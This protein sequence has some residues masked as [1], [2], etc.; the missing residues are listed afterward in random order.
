MQEYWRLDHHV[1]VIPFL[2]E[3]LQTTLDKF[4]GRPINLSR[5]LKFKECM[6]HCG[7]LDLGFSGP[8]FTWTNLRN[9]RALIRE[10]LDRA[11]S[12]H[13]W[14]LLFPATKILHLPRTHSDHCPLLLNIHPLS[15]NNVNRPFRFETI[16]FSDPSLFSVVPDSWAQHPTSFLRSVTTFTSKVSIWNKTSF[17]NIFL[18]KRRLERRLLGVQKALDNQSYSFLLELEKALTSELNLTLKL[19]EEFWALKSRVNTIL[20]GDRNSKFFHIT[21]INRRRNN[22]I[23]ALKDTSGTWIST[24]WLK[25][26]CLSTEPHPSSIPWAIVFPLACWTIWKNRNSASFEP[27]PPN[28]LKPTW[29]ITLATEWYHLSYTSKPRATKTI[30][31]SWK[32]PHIHCFKLN[33]DDAENENHAAVGGIIR[34]IHGNWISGFCRFLSKTNSLTAEF[35]ALRDGLKLAL[36][37]GLTPN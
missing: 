25:I 14:Q 27:T 33:T 3:T 1:R 37:M 34:D 11:W 21:T 19:E 24:K 13:E 15:S 9:T 7:M 35:W 20:E 18:K 29:T 36:E 23:S 17:G 32:P 12:N 8:K 2:K 28:P 31:C 26:N 4:G 30:A 5:A 10:R 6:D 16:W 22:S